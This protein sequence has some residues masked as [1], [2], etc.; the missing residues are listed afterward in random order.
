MGIQGVSFD[1]TGQHLTGPA[2]PTFLNGDASRSVD[3]WIFNPDAG[4][5]EPVIAWGRRSDPAGSNSSFNHGTNLDFGALGLWGDPD[6][7]WGDV[8]NVVVGEWTHVAYTYTNTD[9]FETVA[10]SNGVRAFGEPTPFSLATQ[11]V[12]TSG[13]PLRFRVAGQN[14]AN[15]NPSAPYGS[16][17][18]ARI[19]VYDQG[20]TAQQ[21]SDIYEAE[22]DQFVGVPDLTISDFTYDASAGSVTLTWTVAPGSTYAV[23]AS[24][25]VGDTADFQN[26]ATGLD[27]GTFTD[28]VTE[29]TRFYRLQLE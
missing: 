2:A 4:A 13:L 20:L 11:D 14:A 17:T 21:I 27:T 18:I 23:Q 25:T 6:M 1:G 22:S 10:Y 5:E 7:G 9:P 19:R 8:A 3:A 24:S 26:I 29:E 28:D 15:G 16:M 12:D